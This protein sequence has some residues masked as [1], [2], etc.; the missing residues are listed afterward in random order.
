MERHPASDAVDDVDRN[1]FILVIYVI[2]GDIDRAKACSRGE[3]DPTLGAPG[4]GAE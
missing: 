2:G 4:L 3:S 1:R